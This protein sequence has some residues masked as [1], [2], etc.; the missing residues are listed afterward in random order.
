MS[1]GFDGELLGRGATAEVRLARLHG[2]PVA[3]KRLRPE[4]RDDAD[5]IEELQ[6]EAELLREVEHP[7]IVRLLDAGTAVGDSSPPLGAERLGEVGDIPDGLHSASLVRMSADFHCGLPPP[8]RLPHPASPPPSRGRRGVSRL[9]SARAGPFLV[10]EYLGGGSLQRLVPLPPANA[11]ELLSGIAAALT[12]LH[13][14]GIVHGDIKPS[15]LLRDSTGCVK[16]IDFGAAWRI[17][18]PPRSVRLATPAYAAPELMLGLPPDPRDDIFSLAIV[19]YR[20]LAGRHPFA[21][22]PVLAMTTPPRPPGLDD[23]TWRWLRAALAPA[24]ADRP[25]D[26]LPVTRLATACPA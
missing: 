10:L 9:P 22:D 12:A 8:P 15:H 20:L 11:A 24:R 16:L 3:I 26:A 6:R 19:F 2:Q 7:S 25:G 4:Y 14:R 5:A 21:G 18:D 13:R 1:P 23:N 17:G